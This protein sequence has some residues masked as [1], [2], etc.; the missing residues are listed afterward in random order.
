MTC[1]PRG[2]RAMLMLPAPSNPWALSRPPSRGACRPCSRSH[3]GRSSHALDARREC[4]SLECRREGEASSS[5]GGAGSM[6]KGRSAE[7][8]KSWPTRCAKAQYVERGSARISSQGLAES[9]Q[10]NQGC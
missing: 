7:R 4:A 6:R 2:T 5:S 3:A 9:N 10:Q 1:A 8:T